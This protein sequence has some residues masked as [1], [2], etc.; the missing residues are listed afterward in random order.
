M[1]NEPTKPNLMESLDFNP[2]DSKIIHL[3]VGGRQFVTQYQTLKEQSGYF[4]WKELKEGVEYFLDR[5][6]EIFEYLL[7]YM[8]T[9]ILPES[10][11]T[12]RHLLEE[13]KFF[14]MKKLE[15][16]LERG[17]EEE[18]RNPVFATLTSERLQFKSLD[19]IRVPGRVVG[20]DYEGTVRIRQTCGPDIV[21]HNWNILVEK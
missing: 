13:A 20:A 10:R 9:G 15:R 17:L 5:N 1:S 16:K 18:R 21:Y 6:G 12:R 19:E 14:V 4:H 3:N 11:E 8:R 7:E 2:E